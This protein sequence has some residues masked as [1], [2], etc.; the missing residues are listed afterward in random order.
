[1]VAIHNPLETFWK[2]IKFLGLVALIYGFSWACVILFQNNIN[3]IDDARTLSEIVNNLTIA[4]GV[5]VGGVWAYYQYI[6]GRLFAPKI[7]LGYSSSII[8]MSN[9]QR[10]V[11]FEISIKNIGLV[12][13]IPDDCIV[14]IS[15]FIINNE[16]NI[17]SAE[18]YNSY[19]LPSYKR[20]RKEETPLFSKFKSLGLDVWYIEPNET[21]NLSK[22]VEV[23]NSYEA[24]YAEITFFYNKSMVA[25][26]TFIIN[27]N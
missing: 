6:N 14:E 13:V 9:K 11:L 25:N 2:V 17:V 19:F 3:S 4:I 21:E 23:S 12:R 20:V 7:H 15:G 10:I 1:M 8:Q 16:G 24:L 18:I 5:M 22:L 27:L 26:Q